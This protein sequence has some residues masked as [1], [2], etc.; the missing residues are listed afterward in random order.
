MATIC[1]VRRG[2]KNR[3]NGVGLQ[4][5]WLLEHELKFAGSTAIGHQVTLASA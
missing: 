3:A 4:K 1:K 2:R 5:R